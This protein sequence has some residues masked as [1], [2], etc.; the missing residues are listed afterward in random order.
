[1]ERK[2]V[3]LVTGAGGDMGRAEA[4]ALARHRKMDIAVIYRSS[5]QDAETTVAACRS[6]GV[7][8]RAF[9]ADLRESGAVRGLVEQVREAMGPIS[10]LVNN[11]GAM[12]ATFNS[13]LVEMEPEIWREMIEAHLTSSFLCIKYCAPDMIGAGWGRIINTSSIHGRTG[14]RATLGAYGAAKAGIEALTKTAAR[15]LG[16][17]GITSNCIAPGF[18]ATARLKSYMSEERITQLGQQIP[19]GRIASPDEIASVVAFLASDEASYVNGAVIDVN[20]GRTEYL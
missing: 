11:A 19:V 12:G 18:V 20:G 4:I 5:S 10:V 3:A 6:V 13:T 2:G 8:A 17:H 16:A 15:E 9:G 1:M 7:Q 14:G